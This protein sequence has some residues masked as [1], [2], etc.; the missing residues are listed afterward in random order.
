M[1]SQ[2]V[3]FLNKNV[4]GCEANSEARENGDTPVF[5]NASHILAA[6][7]ALKES[8]ETDMTT[9]EVITG[10]DYEDRIEVSYILASFRKNTEVILKVKLDKPSTQAL[11]EIDSVCSIW[12]AANFQEREC[13]DMLGVSFKGHPD[14][15]RILCPEDWEGYP[16]RKDYKVQ[17]TYRDMT[18]NPEDKMN[19]DDHYFYKKVQEEAE[20]PK[21]VTFS[22]K[23]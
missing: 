6:C 8:S 17:E 20:E 7:K 12:K 4:T 15:R 14:E 3:E 11:V 23:H 18:V 5:L 9:L 10:C 16:L 21:K 13:F 22:W 2:I 19:Q 1:H